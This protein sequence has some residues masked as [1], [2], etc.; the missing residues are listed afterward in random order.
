M[1]SVL[2]LVCCFL[3]FISQLL[4]WYHKEY[5]PKSMIFL[6]VFEATIIKVQIIFASS[7]WYHASELTSACNSVL[8]QCAD[9]LA[10]HRMNTNYDRHEYLRA[11]EFY[12]YV[13]KK[14]IGFCVLGVKISFAL[15]LS[16]LT[17]LF[18]VVSIVLPVVLRTYYS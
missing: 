7:V 8:D 12:Q 6:I 10:F 3:G 17:P 16:I 13:E 9:V 15:G 4:D 2:V 11:N 1:S 18:S 14:N 5:Q